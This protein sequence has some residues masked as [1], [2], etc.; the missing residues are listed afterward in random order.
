M[1]GQVIHR[2]VLR[3]QHFMPI[4]KL[5][6]PLF[7]L[8]CI[9]LLMSV[10]S[11]SKD[12]GIGDKSFE[13]KRLNEIGDK[14]PDTSFDNVKESAA[15]S[16]HH[17]KERT[18]PSDRNS[19]PQIKSVRLLPEVFKP[20]DSL[21]IEAEATDPDGDEVTISYEWYK[22][23]EL[24][25]T[26]KQLNSP[27]KRGDKLLIKIKP[28]DGKDYG[29]VVTLK[30]EILNTPPVIQDHKDYHFDE[31]TFSYQVKA[32]D[33]DGDPLTYSLKT[34]PEGMT[35][36]NTGLIKWNVPPQFKG[37]IPITVSVTDGH[38]GEAIQSFELDIGR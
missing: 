5:I 12:E 33:P 7:C 3:Y 20:D 35:I 2:I 34:S 4:R 21:Y 17:E 29:K 30:R 23:G 28:F 8:A 1:K 10:A 24:V 11:C 9:F 32:F 22:N 6:L 37:K 14:I 15:D 38:G 19:P 27:I 26:E 13:G 31:K 16:Q 18:I 36:D 25:S